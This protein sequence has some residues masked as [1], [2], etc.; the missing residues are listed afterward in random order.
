MTNIPYMGNTIIAIS[1]HPI[2]G[3]DN[4]PL[5][6]YKDVGSGT[7]CDYENQHLK[8]DD[9]NNMFKDERFSCRPSSYNGCKTLDCEWVI[10]ITDAQ[11]AENVRKREEDNMVHY[12]FDYYLG[13]YTAKHDDSPGILGDIQQVPFSYLTSYAGVVP[14]EKKSTMLSMTYEFSANPSSLQALNNFHVSTS[15]SDAIL[16]LDVSD[17]GRLKFIRQSNW[18]DYGYAGITTVSSI[19]LP[20]DNT[21]VY[22]S[23]TITGTYCKGATRDIYYHW[24]CS[25][26]FPFHHVV[27][28]HAYQMKAVSKE[29]SISGYGRILHSFDGRSFEASKE[30]SPILIGDIGIWIVWITDQLTTTGFEIKG[31]PEL[32]LM[33]ID[34]W[35]GS[36]WVKFNWQLGDY[37]VTKSSNAN[38]LPEHFDPIIKNSGKLFVAFFVQANE[39]T[40]DIKAAGH[41]GKVVVKANVVPKISRQRKINNRAVEWSEPQFQSDSYHKQSLRQGPGVPAWVGPVVGVTSSV[42]VVSGVVLIVV[43][44]VFIHK[45]RIQNRKYEIIF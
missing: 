9:E 38:L 3:T 25:E 18:T 19:L 17:P 29:A 31:A 43:V 14:A 34:S 35:L 42:L 22:S 6:S 5:K 33:F 8:C 10:T 24:S 11:D 4:L 16:D 27:P 37:N 20:T 41:S 26:T 1:D 36:G 7:N 44:S 2:S 28:N 12:I 15:R 32:D 23:I 13:Y 21:E 30:T 45:R 40:S 39:H